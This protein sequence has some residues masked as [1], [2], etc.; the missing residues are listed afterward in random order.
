MKKPASSSRFVSI[1][2][3]L[4]RSRGRASWEATAARLGGAPRWDSPSIPRARAKRE[5]G[6]AASARRMAP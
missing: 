3:E 4:N 1:A 2:R 5:P 6:A